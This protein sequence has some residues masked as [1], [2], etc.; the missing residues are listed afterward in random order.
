MFKLCDNCKKRPAMVYI[1]QYD[2]NNKE[3]TGNSMGYCL[4]CAKKLG[5][6]IIDESEFVALI[7]KN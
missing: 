2:P 3:T 1:Q 6:K 4:I 7:N 5:I